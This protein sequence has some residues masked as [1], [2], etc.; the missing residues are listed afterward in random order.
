MAIFIQ[1][2]IPERKTKGFKSKGQKTS[3]VTQ[4]IHNEEMK[5]F[6]QLTRNGKERKNDKKQ[7]H[8]EI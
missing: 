7:L 8:T 3:Q 5:F 1:A 4:R 6:R 2:N